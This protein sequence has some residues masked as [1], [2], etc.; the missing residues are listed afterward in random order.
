MRLSIASGHEVIISISPMPGSIGEPRNQRSLGHEYVSADADENSPNHRERQ[1]VG[2]SSKSQ[3]AEGYLNE[4]G[5]HDY[6]EGFGE[7]VGV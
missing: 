7:T 5:H 1:P 4:S 6:C 2:E 3:S